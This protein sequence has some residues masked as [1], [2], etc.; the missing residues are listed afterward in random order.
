VPDTVSTSAQEHGKPPVFLLDAM[1]F[2]FRA[3]H[4][5]QR[6]R[7]MS[8][9]SGLP[10]AA[11]YVFVNMIRKLRQ[12][13]S[14]RYF[15]AVFDPSGA[16]FRDE[17][18]QAIG[19]LRKWNSKLQSFEEVS[20]EGYKAKRESMPDDLRR[21]VPY[22]RRSL[23]ALHIPI[24]EA[25]G[26]EADDVIGTLAREAAEQ[27]HEVFIVSGDKDMMQLVNNHVKVLNPQKDNLILDAAKVQEVLG[28]PPEKVVDVMALRGDTIDNIPG[29]PGIGDK[30]SVDLIVE[31]GSL[32]AVLERAAEVKRKS[33]R[34]SLEQ[35]RDA[36]LLSKELV[37]ID[38]HVPLP[39]DLPAMETQEPDLEACRALFSELEFTSMLRE[40]AP[41]ASAPAL[42]LID[43]PSDEQA[44]A[45]YAAARKDG[46]AFALAAS[47]PAQAEPDADEPSVPQ[48]M[49]LL[50]AVEEAERKTQ[51]SVGVCAEAGT[52]LCLSLTPELKALLEDSAVPKRVHDLKLALHV[53]CGLEVDLRGKVEDSQLL[54]YA[55]NPTHTTQTLADVAARHNQTQPK[56]LPAAAAI[57]QTLVTEL[58][59]EADRCNVTSV[60]ETIDL[61]L[62]PVLYRMEKA[63]V[64]IDNDVLAKLS[65]RFGAEIERVSERIYELAGERFNIS[66]P[67]KLGEVLFTR[68][69]LPMPVKYGK[70][71]TISTAQDVLEPLAEKFEV[72]R[73]VLEYRH[74]SKLKSTYIDVL[75]RQADAESRVHTTFQ[76]AATATGRLS[77]FNPNLQNIPIR[78]ELGREIRAAFVASPGTELLSA[79]Y[80]QI[81]LRL[82]AHFSSDPLLVRAY[83]Q[84]EDIHT[85]TASEVFGV[86]AETMDKETRNRAK[87]VN[88]GIVYGISPFGLAA[89]LGIPQAEARAYIDRYFARYE[90]VKA[91]IEKTLEDT[92]R[93]GAVRTMFGRV[94]PIPDITSRNPNARGFAERTAVNTPLQGTAADLIKLAMISLDRKLAD[95]R[96]KTRMVLQVHDELLFEV[97]T[98]EKRE[99]ED[100]VRAEME[101]VVKLN[102]PLLADLG[103]GPNW[104]DL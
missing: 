45:F 29:A 99:V 18:A 10:T 54:S 100:L 8:T 39:L 85:L 83:Q 72:V 33:Y 96:L 55:L 103:F 66:S 20:Y 71:K 6:S 59:A 64:R 2:I 1:S 25:Q 88:F 50:D 69:E 7:P 67:K 19:T 61:P 4:A 48:T 97:P 26:F 17:R 63:G 30:G 16:V 23:E 14:P 104:R 28:V 43:H 34:E 15:A 51:S 21:Q 89:Q 24:L 102:V 95:R 75:P 9:R 65:T 91:F 57:T 73:L 41:S 46:F 82:L 68:M 81:E 35:N 56:S 32:D 47:E 12:D 22:I 62:A 79:D 31:F 53:L 98:E 87:A 3:Y 86:P 42:Q 76:A 80:S 44:A 77:S 94:R 58:R 49:S 27:G 52:G 11:T 13:F 36:V 37:T 93:E 90:G 101:G 70:G 40:L 78:T 60:Y 38:C 74:L 92:R 5:M 84:N